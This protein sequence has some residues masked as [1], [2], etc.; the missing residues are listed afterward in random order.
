MLFAVN[1]TT[2][3]FTPTQRNG[4]DMYSKNIKNKKRKYNSK[5]SPSSNPQHQKY[6]QSLGK[7][8]KKMPKNTTELQK[9]QVE[10]LKSLERQF[11]RLLIRHKAGADIY[12]NFIKQIVDINKNVLTA[13]PYFRE[14]STTFKSSISPA[15]TNRDWLALTRFDI[16]GNFVRWVLGTRDWKNDLGGRGLLCCARKIKK[17]R[18]EL[19]VMN[20]PLAIGNATKFEKGN[21][22]SHL[23]AE[24][25]Q[26]FSA[27]G[28]IDGVE[29]YAAE[30]YSK[31]FR[32]VLLGRSTGSLIEANSRGLIH[33]YPQ[34]RKT[35]YRL[36][37]ML[38]NTI[39][40]S[41][42]DLNELHQK[43]NQ[44]ESSLGDILTPIE[45]MICLLTSSH[46][47]AASNLPKECQDQAQGSAKVSVIDS[48]PD[49]KLSPEE[50]LKRS[51]VINQ[52]PTIIEGLSI[53]HQKILKLCGQEIG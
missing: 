40:E 18:D 26:G 43:L 11:R 4:C 29:K 32:S 39:I 22:M 44:F 3:K 6:I 27:L 21:K 14:R 19:V 7:I 47:V 16:N 25:F 48:Y 30:T 33:L 31:V 46:V 34:H 42:E 49:Q 45:E 1:L 17:Q 37:K 8:L 5:R 9:E 36:R 50:E 41:S 13:R 52:L 51:E 12:R 23:K 15:L 28:L 20:L 53:I 35:L 24:D 10:K 38:K 2:T